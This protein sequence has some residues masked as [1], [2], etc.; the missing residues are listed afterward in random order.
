MKHCK[1]LLIAGLALPTAIF[2]SEAK[3]NWSHYCSRCHGPNGAGKTKIGKK[4]EVKDYTNA[5]VQAKITSDE[6][7][8]TILEGATQNG[9]ER[10]P[11][12]KAKLSMVE[13]KALVAYVR[14]FKK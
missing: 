7:L 13:A 9:K 10:M 5:A 2:A 14:S 6:M 12:Y 3:E 1:L 11:A 4:L 8:K